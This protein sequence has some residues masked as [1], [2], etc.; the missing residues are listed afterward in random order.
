M[1]L[2]TTAHV[3]ISNVSDDHVLVEVLQPTPARCGKLQRPWWDQHR[4]MRQRQSKLLG[5]TNH[6]KD[7]LELSSFYHSRKAYEIE[8]HQMDCSLPEMMFDVDDWYRF[9]LGSNLHLWTQGLCDAWFGGKDPTRGKRRMRTLL[10]KWIWLDESH[11]NVALL[12]GKE[13]SPWHCYF[14]SVEAQCNA[15]D[16]RPVVQKFNYEAYPAC[17]QG[18]SQ[19]NISS[20]TLEWRAVAMEYLFRH[21][22]PL[23][24]HEAERQIGIIFGNASGADKTNLSPVEVPSNLVVVHVRWGDKYKEMALPSMDEYIQA[25]NRIVEARRDRQRL[26]GRATESD[27]HIFLATEDPKAIHAFTEQADPSWKIYVDLVGN[28]FGWLRPTDGNH[29]SDTSSYTKGRSGLLALGSLILALE[30]VDFVLTL[31][32]NWS[33]VMN[34]LRVNI[35]DPWCGNCTN[36][37][38]LRPEKW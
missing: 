11:C 19:G 6:D 21:V 3:T 37:I 33:R 17:N 14:E 26:S 18:D 24:L 27:V 22:S 2:A 4:R 12:M 31:A 38:D 7:A 36:M 1:D 34:M 28:E 35:I 9:G 23:V 32:S 8:Q 5:P 20:S 30:G 15:T 13:S 16:V 25:T 10:T 29:A